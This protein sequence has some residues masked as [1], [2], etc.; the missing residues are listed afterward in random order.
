V[1]VSYEIL[2]RS[3]QPWSGVLFGQIKRDSSKD[4]SSENHSF[5]MVTFLG[6]AWWTA[7]KNYN[8][9][10]LA[11]FAEE[12]VNAKVTGGWIAMVQHYFV[13]A[14]VPD[15]KTQNYVSTRADN[16]G[17]DHIISFTGSPLTVAAG[18]QG[19]VSADFYAGPKIQDHL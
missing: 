15:S 2:N 10:A 7:E 13:S 3:A 1:K 17:A 12:P 5:G 16:N 14:W 11:K 4:P 9:L 8:K 19:T 6:G 18:G